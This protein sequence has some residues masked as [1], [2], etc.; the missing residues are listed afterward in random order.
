MKHLIAILATLSF[1]LSVGAQDAYVVG[2]S[3]AMTGPNA[4]T[5]APGVESVK[6]Y[7]DKLNKQGGV[8]GK[9]VKLIIGDNQGEPSKA[10]ADAKRFISQDNAILLVN[11]GLS[12]SYGPMVAEAKRAR[13]PLL[14]AGAACPAEVLP[15]TPDELQFCSIAAAMKYDA[16]MALRFIKEQSREPVKLGLAAMAIP[17]SRAGID[18]AESLAPG[19]GMTV[20]HKEQIPPATP[21]YTPYASKL[22]GTEPNWVYSWAPWVTEVRTFEALRKVGWNGRYIAAALN[23]AEDELARVKDEGFHGLAANAMFIEN[24]PIHQE[25]HEAARGAKLTYPVTQ[26]AEGWV[27]GM[28]IEQTLKAVAWPPTPE[29]VLAAMSNLKVDTKGL[30]GGPIEWNKSNHFRT[31]QYYRIYRWDAKKA[32]VTRVQD[33]V[34]VDVK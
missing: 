18:L 17:V 28:V 30:R 29:K 16:E 21:D 1:S 15:P 6:L 25:I 12:S 20:V 33:W 19:M 34:T 32:A 7:I 27:A 24:L 8:N 10:A 4:D 26:L 2:L 14:F 31:K 9:P 3:G 5:Y 13:V 11:V 22:K 23:P